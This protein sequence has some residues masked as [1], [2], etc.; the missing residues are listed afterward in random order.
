[1]RAIYLIFLLCLTTLFSFS[2]GIKQDSTIKMVYLGSPNS[3]GGVDVAINWY[4]YSEKTVKYIT[5]TI[6]PY[7]AVNDVCYCSITKKA[8]L[9]L[10]ATG[11]YENGF[12]SSPNGGGAW[13]DIW[14]NHDIA[15]CILTKVTIQYMD[16]KQKVISGLKIK[17]SNG[18]L[19]FLNM[20]QSA[21]LKKQSK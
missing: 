13:S 7:N 17:S 15:Y 18:Y 16:G 12:Q 20:V 4:N 3:V 11:P 2:Q 6:T 19:E 21:N 10:K 5:F 9:S 14:Y 8:T 1:M